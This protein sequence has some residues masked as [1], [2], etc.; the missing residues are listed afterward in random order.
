MERYRK[1]VYCDWAFLETMTSKLEDSISD[2]DKSFYADNEMASSIKEL[3][4]SNDIKLYLNIAEEE[5]QSFL[6]EIEKKRTK[7]Y[8]KGK[9]PELNELE[10]LIREISHKQQVNEVH[11]HFNPSK[12]KFDDSIINDNNLNAVFLSCE[13]SDVCRKAMQD[14]GIIVM[15]PDTINDFDFF[16]IDQG[17]ALRKEEESNW[18]VCL[19]SG[20]EI[21]PCNAMILVDNYILNNKDGFEENIKQILNAI[22]PQKL[23]E[24][25]TF[26]FMIFTT[27]SSDSGRNTYNCRLRLK[28]VTE[29]LEELRP[30][31]K[32]ATSIV[33]CSRD[34]FHD[35]TIISNNLYI[36]CGGGF[37]L[38]RNGEAKKTTTINQINPFFNTHTK[39]SKKAYSNLLND[40]KSVL[41]NAI[42]SDERMTENKETNGYHLDLDN[43]RNVFGEKHNRLIDLVQ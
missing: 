5:Y 28:Q 34:K 40:A 11:L 27:L 3:V 14:Y 23:H 2:F 13:S 21:V 18:N 9:E 6:R 38:F 32:F 1:T 17:V 16:T 36:S 26:Q 42:S 12:V 10:K 7:A 39:W 4:L 22:I 19:S 25:I 33:K 43:L 35:R 37:D 30:E 31:I 20:H 24:S 8:K 15:S 41:C 29:I